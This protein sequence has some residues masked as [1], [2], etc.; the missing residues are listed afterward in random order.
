MAKLDFTCTCCN[1]TKTFDTFD[2]KFASK[3]SKF[4][5]GHNMQGNWQTWKVKRCKTCDQILDGK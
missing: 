3:I 1:I 2:K 5:K 4:L